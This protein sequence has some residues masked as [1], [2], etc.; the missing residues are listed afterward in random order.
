MREKERKIDRQTDTDIAYRE[1]TKNSILRI[2][3]RQAVA[4][5]G[6]RN[7]AAWTDGQHEK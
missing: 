5:T 4:Y 3:H 2:G 7:I 1:I 6:V